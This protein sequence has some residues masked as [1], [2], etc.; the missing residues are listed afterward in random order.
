MRNFYKFTF[1]LMFSICAKAQVPTATI[2]S[3][4]PVFCTD[5]PIWFVA[6][7]ADTLNTFNWSIANKWATVNHTNDSTIICTFSNAGVYTLSVS[8]TNSVGTTLVTR[9][10]SVTRSAKASFNANLISTGYP[11]EL[12][13]TNYSSNSLK[14]YW[15]FSDESFRDSSSYY[16]KY[17]GTS[18]NYT[19]T[20][21]A[22]GK[23]GCNDTLDY[24]FRISDSSSVV[25]PNIFTPNND[26]VNDVFKPQVRGIL[27]L[28]AW[29]YNRYGILMHS[30]DKV[31]GTWDGY[32]TSGI[33]CRAG[34]YFVVVEAT[35][36]DGKTYKLKTSL[37]LIK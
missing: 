5:V 30:W 3:V 32:T 35:G 19:V 36:F 29:V 33:E 37:T 7:T 23:N 12:S 25:L 26:D 18:G 13:L 8:V 10:V 4:D 22:I 31:N 15:L 1:V 16:T 2:L 21:V 34:E 28:E 14:N 17:Y 9:N 6:R 11:N 24:S 20:L 27:K